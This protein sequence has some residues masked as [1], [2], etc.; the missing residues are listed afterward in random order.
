MR[1]SSHDRLPALDGLRGLAILLVL[2]FHFGSRFDPDNW[3][4]TLFLRTVNVGWAGVD[5]FFVLSGFLITGILYDARGGPAYFRAFYIRRI[6][7]IFPL[8]Y[9]F[10]GSYAVLLPWLLPD[11]PGTDLFTRSQGWWWAYASN[12]RI[13]TSGFQSAPL[14]TSPMWS[15]AVEEQFYLLWPLFVFVIPTNLARWCLYLFAAAFVVRVALVASGWELA[16]MVLTPARMDCFAIGGWLAIVGRE[17][18]LESLTVFARR[19]VAMSGIALAIMWLMDPRPADTTDSFRATI[20][21]SLIAILFAGGVASALNDAS[22]MWGRI[23][24]SR[25]FRWFGKYSYGLYIYHCPVRLVLDQLALN[26][27]SLVDQGVSW[28]AAVAIFSAIGIGASVALAVLSWRFFESPILSLK[29]F[30][31]YRSQ[32]QNVG[33]RGA[34]LTTPA[35]ANQKLSESMLR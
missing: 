19:A 6:L 30:V 26:P 8:Y 7:R 34:S 11:H 32:H 35:G 1:L 28:I 25:A 20:G 29:R 5:L 23:G 33:L 13:A 12:V 2:V 18:G 21:F 16:A 9:L 31:P 24:H 22:G 10:I 3:I 4:G 15:L 17:R 14:Y 27:R